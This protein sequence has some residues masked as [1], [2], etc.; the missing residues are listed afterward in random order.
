[1]ET[2]KSWGEKIQKNPGKQ[3]FEN[4]K[5]T[6]IKLTNKKNRKK[7]KQQRNKIA[8][9]IDSLYVEKVGKSNI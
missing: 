2:R 1:M 9:F 8:T 5:K 4:P 3:K 6:S 7:Q